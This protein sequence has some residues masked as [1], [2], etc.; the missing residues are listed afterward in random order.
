MDSTKTGKYYWVIDDFLYIGERKIDK[1]KHGIQKIDN[2]SCDEH[3]IQFSLNIPGHEDD[4][5]TETLIRNTFGSGYTSKNGDN[6]AELFTNETHNFIFG[7]WTENGV[8][9]TW[10]AKAEK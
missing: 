5:Y 3:M 8:D 6:K 4:G 10:W 7:T 1:C 2:V 9:Y